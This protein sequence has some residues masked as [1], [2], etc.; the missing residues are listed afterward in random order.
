MVAR[1]AERDE[2]LRIGELARI[3]GTTVRTLHH[4]EHVGLLAAPARTRGRQRRYGAR[5]VERLYVIRALRELGLGLHE[6]RTTLADGGGALAE[7]LASHRARVA[8]EL[9]QRRR[10]L[11]LLDHA[12]RGARRGSTPRDL[13]A[14]I[15]AMAQLSRRAPRPDDTRASRWRA[16]G[17]RLHARKKAG[18]R[19][20]SPA[21]RAI[22]EEVRAQIHAF[23]GG[24]ARTIE[25][26]ATLRRRAPPEALAGWTPSL[27]R[28]LDRAIAAIER[29][30]TRA[31]R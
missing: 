19:P 17:A 13:L 23:A 3:A 8:R 31:S 20:S 7:V 6:I 22:A 30:E 18:A 2:G 4:Y 24:D 29:R 27:F 11:T 1:H 21:V 25:A 16:L 12:C 26:L 15:E 9:A 28:Y 5:D 10:L 14:T